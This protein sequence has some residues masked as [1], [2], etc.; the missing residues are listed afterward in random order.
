MLML[1]YYTLKIHKELG[2]HTI[3]CYL[4]NGF[5]IEN[6]LAFEH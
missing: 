1:T 6:M 4:H 2:R 5:I 3:K